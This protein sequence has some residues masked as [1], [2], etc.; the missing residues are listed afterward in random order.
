MDAVDTDV[1]RRA[2]FLFKAL[3]KDLPFMFFTGIGYF[4]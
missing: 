3:L 2:E 1:D 4:K